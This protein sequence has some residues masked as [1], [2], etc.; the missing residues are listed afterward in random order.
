MHDKNDEIMVNGSD[1]GFSKEDLEDLDGIVSQEEETTQPESNQEGKPQEEAQAEEPKQEET[2]QET[3]QPEAEEP[4]AEPQEEPKQE[5]SNHGDLNK[6]L[7]E[8]RSRRKAMTSEI[9]ALKNQIAEMRKQATAQEPAIPPQTRQQI[10]DNARNEAAKR[11]NIEHVE[12]LMFT[13]PKKYEEFLRLQGAIAYQNE[14][15]IRAQQ[16]VYNQNVA[17]AQEIMNTPNIQAVMARGNEILDNMTRKDAMEI[18]QAFS[19][20][21]AGR[22]NKKDF[23]IIRDFR[24]RV[25]REMA[26]HVSTPAQNQAAKTAEKNPLEQAAALPKASALTGANPVQPKI[27]NDEILRAVREGRESE[28]PKEIQRAISNICGE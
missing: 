24:D 16:A 18:D 21:D 6:A 7:A 20:V 12:D 13:E 15:R 11:L 19:R 14:S 25:V 23:K 4:Q 8:E 10:L 3:K 28:L 26:N 17:F 2:A 5:P 22:G 9:E 1:Y 27:S